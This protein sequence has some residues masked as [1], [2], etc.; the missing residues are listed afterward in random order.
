MLYFPQ[1]RLHIRLHIYATLCGC[2]DSESRAQSSLL[3]TAEAH[4]SLILSYVFISRIFA[5][6]IQT[7]FKGEYMVIAI[8]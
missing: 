5:P 3:E 7:F 1:L 4:P 6:Y 2:K 8:R